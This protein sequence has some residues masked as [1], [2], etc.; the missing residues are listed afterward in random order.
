M[1]TS[2]PYLLGNFLW[3]IDLLGVFKE[4]RHEVLLTADVA[5]SDVL[6]KTVSCHCQ[7][8]IFSRRGQQSP[9]KDLSFSWR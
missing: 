5:C 6:N 1:N 3:V 9:V 7:G 4:G 8:G 2:V